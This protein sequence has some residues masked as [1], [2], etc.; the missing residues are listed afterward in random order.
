MNSYFWDCC[1]CLELDCFED[2]VCALTLDCLRNWIGFGLGL[3]TSTT[4][5]S[6]GA[7]DL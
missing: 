2:P 3:R 1:S 5:G 7:T 6:F 4:T